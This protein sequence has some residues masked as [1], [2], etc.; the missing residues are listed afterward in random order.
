M[1]ITFFCLTIQPLRTYANTINV[2]M[3]RVL[4]CG[5]Y[6]P[7]FCFRVHK[8]LK[9]VFKTFQTPSVPSSFIIFRTEYFSLKWPLKQFHLT[10]ITCL[11]KLT[12]FINTSF[13]NLETCSNRSFRNWD[14]LI[15]K[16]CRLNCWSIKLKQ[17]MKI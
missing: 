15:E 3:Q 1:G 10:N 4:L 14:S 8:K 11:N 16:N 2:A 17:K 9:A 7:N 12:F 5:I 6:N 13:H